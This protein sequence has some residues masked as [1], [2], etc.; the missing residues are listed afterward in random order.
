MN[1]LFLIF[2][3]VVITS[4]N[5]IKTTLYNFLDIN[6]DGR[7]SA[8][9]NSSS[10]LTGAGL[11]Y[12]ENPALLDKDN[13]SVFI[14]FS[15]LLAGASTGAT[16]FSSSFSR[17]VNYGAFIRY[18]SFGDIDARDEQGN[19]ISSSV[20]PYSFD[21]AFSSSYNFYNMLSVGGTFHFAYENLANIEN[22]N[23]SSS[24]ILFDSGILFTPHKRLFLSAGFKN[25]GVVLNRY[26]NDK[27]DLPFNYY[28]AIRYKAGVL[29][30]VNLKLELNKAI[31]N[32]LYFIPAMEFLFNR[33]IG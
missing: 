9:G 17:G 32:P 18:F 15:P 26:E 7:G 1:R 25:L 10:T 14:A 27:S 5:D 33:E 6:I 16:S 21:V 19:K 13:T 22:E 31:Y 24:A 8:L 29:T 2:I 3:I 4:A 28:S 12:L 30:R 20:S 23:I 11:Q